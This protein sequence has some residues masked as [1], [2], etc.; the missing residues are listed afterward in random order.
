MFFTITNCQLIYDWKFIQ[1]S[2]SRWKAGKSG[3]VAV[4]NPSDESLRANLTDVTSLAATLTVHHMSRAAR[5][6]AK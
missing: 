2:C 6:L 5:L 3:Y 1:C 4:Y